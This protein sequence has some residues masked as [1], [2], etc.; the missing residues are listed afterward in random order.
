M[1]GVSYCLIHSLFFSQIACPLNYRVWARDATTL[2]T[3]TS[4]ASGSTSQMWSLETLSSRLAGDITWYLALVNLA[5]KDSE[6][7]F[8]PLKYQMFPIPRYLNTLDQSCV[9]L[10]VITLCRSVWI[11]AI[12]CQSLTTATMWCAATSGTPGT[13]PTFPAATYLRKW[14]LVQ[15]EKIACTEVWPR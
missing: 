11:P 9:V 13:T 15:S 7:Q 4:T 5:G 1:D 12:R 10:F 14:N 6:G 3:R 2:I 8:N